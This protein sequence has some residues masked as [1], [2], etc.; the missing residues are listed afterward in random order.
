MAEQ[1]NSVAATTENKNIN[2]INLN[3]L[4]NF[5]KTLDS[6][7]EKFL[8]IRAFYQLNYFDLELNDREA[9]EE[10]LKPIGGTK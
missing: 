4:F 6:D 9:L 3:T 7:V 2:N 5:T 1:K 10:L 8:V